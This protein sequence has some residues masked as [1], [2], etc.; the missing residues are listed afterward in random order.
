MVPQKL[1]RYVAVPDLDFAFKIARGKAASRWPRD[2]ADHAA[3]AGN[4]L[5][6]GGQHKYAYNYALLES[7]VRQAGFGQVR[8]LRENGGFS[9]VPYGDV[10]LGGEPEGSRVVEARH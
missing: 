9:P 1:K 2:F 7:F 10:M 8:Q 5:F 4:Y 3:Q 6:S